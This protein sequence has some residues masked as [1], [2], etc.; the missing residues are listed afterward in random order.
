MMTKQTLKYGTVI[1][2]KLGYKKDSTA[3]A[4]SVDSST[5]Y[6]E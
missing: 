4:N 1:T 2:V 5:F 6:V 3:A